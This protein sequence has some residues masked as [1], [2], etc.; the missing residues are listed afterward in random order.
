M[1]MVG[2]PNISCLCVL[3]GELS[4]EAD[5]ASKIVRRP[6]LVSFYKR[7]ACL[8][9]PYGRRD[10]SAQAP[11]YTRMHADQDLVSANI[12]QECI[13]F[14]VLAV[15]RMPLFS[16]GISQ[17]P[18]VHFRI[19]TFSASS[20]FF[21]NITNIS[22]HLLSRMQQPYPLNITMGDIQSSSLR[23]ERRDKSPHRR[24]LLELLL[25]IA[26]IPNAR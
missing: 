22:R 11:M 23:C 13:S 10:D 15:D 16:M 18:M 3:R 20:L 12:C 24:M 17:I 21:D 6:V 14:A 8:H 5:H 4:Q 25:N 19:D 2:A 1:K 9:A 26:P 7:Y